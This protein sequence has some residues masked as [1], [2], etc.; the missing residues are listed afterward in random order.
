[1][2]GGEGGFWRTRRREERREGSGREEGRVPRNKGQTDRCRN[3][4]EGYSCNRADRWNGWEKQKRKTED[5]K[6]KR[7]ARGEEI[8][9]ESPKGI[10]FARC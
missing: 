10:R 2:D 9:T 1:M 7:R 3:G 6:E 8:G 5:G 4:K